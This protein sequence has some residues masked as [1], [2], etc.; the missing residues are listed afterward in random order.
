MTASRW[1]WR[2]RR[3]PRSIRRAGRQQ[4]KLYADCLEAMHG[5]RPIIFYTNGYE[6]YLWDDQAYAPRAV[7]GFHKKD[8]LA[9]L[10]HRRVHREP[11]DVARVKN[12]I[13]ERYYQKR[14]IGSI[15]EQFSQVRRKALLVMATGSGKTRVAVALVDL[16]QRAGWVKR[17]L[18]SGRPGVAGEPGG[19]GVQDPPTSVEPS[20]LG[21][22]EG[23]GG[24]GLR[25]HLSDDDGA[26]RRDDGH[27]GPLRGRA[28]RH[29]DHR[30]GAPVGVSEVRSHLSVLRLAA[31]GPDRDASGSG[32]PE[33]LRTLRS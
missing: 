33:H 28:F 24:P 21:D 5:Q 16:L 1:R 20:E 4:A 9:S 11:L 32:R 3:R 31:G 8:E 27:R 14:A 13:V 25:L 7:A 30:R 18:F 22:R 17:A 29:R 6:T 23:Q 15:G 26:D 12:A 19:G 10:L 2:K